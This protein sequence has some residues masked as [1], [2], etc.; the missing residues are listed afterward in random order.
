MKKVL[1][2]MTVAVAAVA[3][4]AC[5]RSSR[6]VADD[7]SGEEVQ[8]ELTQDEQYANDIVG[9]WSYTYTDEEGYETTNTY[10]FNEDKSM[11]ELITIKGV[12][13]T[14]KINSP[15]KWKVRDGIIEFLYTLDE[16]VTSVN[17]VKND[18]LTT[19][20]RN[21]NLEENKKTREYYESGKTYGFTIKEVKS[22]EL[23]IETA[24][25]ETVKLTR[26]S[27]QD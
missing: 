27:L 9:I 13:G 14:I 8:E 11:L 17:D 1:F 10:T 26:D 16:C 15:G 18:E 21:E 5:D 20:L 12:G 23:T 2:I 4:A 6:A 3:F 19:N 24:G 7:A 22:N 25:F